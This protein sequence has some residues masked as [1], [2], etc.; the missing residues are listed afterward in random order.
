MAA[1]DLQRLSSDINSMNQ[2]GT[3]VTG[4]VVLLTELKEE[5]ERTQVFTAVEIAAILQGAAQ[6]MFGGAVQQKEQYV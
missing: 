3:L 6:G 2:P 4:P 5:L 1:G